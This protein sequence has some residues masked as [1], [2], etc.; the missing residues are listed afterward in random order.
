MTAFEFYAIILN[1]KLF[2]FVLL[3]EAKEEKE[4][5]RQGESIGTIV[6]TGK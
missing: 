5:E 6:Y 4:K 2:V 3:R 1:L